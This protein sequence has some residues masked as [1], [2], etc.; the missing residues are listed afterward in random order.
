MGEEAEGL[1]LV[2]LPFV[3]AMVVSCHFSMC[4]RCLGSYLSMARGK[5]SGRPAG[6]IISSAGMLTLPSN[7]PRA[8]RLR[9][10]ISAYPPFHRA[11]SC[12]RYL[13]NLLHL[14]HL[15]ILHSCRQ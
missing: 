8:A 10:V 9:R 13:R 3:V 7:S 2:R 11:A 4:S 15:P 1:R 12:R 14:A 5:P 6:H